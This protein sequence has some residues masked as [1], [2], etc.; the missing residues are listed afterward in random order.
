[1]Y[2]VYIVQCQDKTF[3]TGITTDIERR[4][5]EHNSSKLGA[6]YT[7]FRRPVNLVYAQKYKNRST[8]SKEEA[9]IK[10]LSRSEKIKL[11]EKL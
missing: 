9:R 2:Y 11:I 3:Y 4:L 5:E 8:A 1:M 10:K 6:K 7:T